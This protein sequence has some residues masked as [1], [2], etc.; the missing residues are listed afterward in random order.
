MTQ[1]GSLVSPDR[2]RF[3]F[4][5]FAPLTAAQLR[6][7][8]DD[9]NSAVLVD[10]PVEKEITSMDAARKAGATAMFGEKYGDTVRQVYVRGETGE[11]SRELCGGCH[12]R[13]TGEIGT[14]RVVAEESVAAGVRRVEAVTGWNAVR[15]LREE[16]AVLHRVEG[17]IKAGSRRDLESRVQA[18]LDENDRLKKELQRAQSALVSQSSGDVMDRMETVDGVP[19]LAAE[20]PVDS[21]K[22]LRDAADRLRDRIPSGVGLLGAR[23]G[24][25]ASLLVFVSDDIIRE[26]G[27]RADVLVKEVAKLVEGGGGG[28]PQLA[29]AGG[30]RPERIGEAL[31]AGRDI[32]AR[33]LGDA[34]A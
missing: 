15:H 19:F 7:V 34:G 11:L 22:A 1:A 17:L 23:T 29:T 27:L 20:F 33:L 9:V 26:R 18:M 21:V 6:A 12:L 10:A 24:E 13:R 2:L 4:N 16:D 14:F 5:H 3:D 28:K 31:K 30:K 25:K 8:E 32:L